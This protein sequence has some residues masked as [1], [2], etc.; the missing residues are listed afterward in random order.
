VDSGLDFTLSKSHEVVP[1][2]SGVAHFNQNPWMTW[3]TAFREVVKLK[4]FQSET[5]TVETAH[6]LK[7]WLSKAQGLHSE[8]CLRGAADAVEY[9]DSVEGDFSKLMLS[10][11]WSWLQTYYDSKYPIR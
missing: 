4:Q 3:R 8:W 5:P 9:Y 1:I 11:E 7:V 2:L 6:R 10:Y